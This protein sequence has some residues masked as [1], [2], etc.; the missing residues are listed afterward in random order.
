MAVHMISGKECVALRDSL[1]KHLSLNIDDKGRVSYADVAKQYNVNIFYC[2]IVVIEESDDEPARKKIHKN[3]GTMILEVTKKDLENPPSQDQLT[4]PEDKML[5]DEVFNSTNESGDVTIKSYHTNIYVAIFLKLI[6]KVDSKYKLECVRLIRR[7]MIGVTATYQRCDLF[8]SS[9]NELANASKNSNTGPD[10]LVFS[11]G[12]APKF[13]LSDIIE[14]D[15]NISIPNDA[16]DKSFLIFDVMAHFVALKEKYGTKEIGKYTSDDLKSSVIAV[17]FQTIII[18]WFSAF[19]NPDFTFIHDISIDNPQDS[20]VAV[21]KD[22]RTKGV[23]IN[24]DD[25]KFFILDHSISK[26]T[27]SSWEYWKQLAESKQNYKHQET[28]TMAVGNPNDQDTKTKAVS[29]PN[30]Q[31]TKTKQAKSNW[32]TYMLWGGV[33]IACLVLVGLAIYLACV[34]N[35]K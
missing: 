12:A 1:V 26:D 11:K 17:N 14:V 15:L 18:T 33:V 20:V 2:D 22:I 30:D 10:P 13:L 19:F 21:F 5:L 23:L 3:S 29:N 35:S 4:I 8:S 6:S 31:D 34:S 32:K 9:L 25:P 28:K 24:D 16:S 27:R 7:N